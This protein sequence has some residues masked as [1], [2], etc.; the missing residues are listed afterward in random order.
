M[1]SNKENQHN[2][3][4]KKKGGTL[5]FII[6]MLSLSLFVSFMV[7]SLVK[8]RG[9]KIIENLNNDSYSATQPSSKI[10]KGRGFED[11]KT[12]EELN[13]EI[14]ENP[15]DADLYN[16]SGNK[17][18]LDGEFEDA[19]EAFNKAIK[20]NPNYSEPYNGKGITYRNLGEYSKAIESY[21]KAIEL[22]PSFFEAYNNRGVCFMF[23]GEYSKMCFDFNK[24]CEL[25]SCQKIEAS[26]AKGL[27]K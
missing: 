27:C 21:T 24:A 22:Y 4:E 6:I 9:Q 7:K 5:K 23:L 20:I 17:Y 26:K 18:L 2:H 8:T 14:N 25:G 1:T 16:E 19:I 3:H 10:E 12:V 15:Q 13:Q 11:E